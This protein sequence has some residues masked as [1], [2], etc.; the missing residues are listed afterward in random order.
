MDS[1]WSAGLSQISTEPSRRFDSFI[2]KNRFFLIS[3]IEIKIHIYTKSHQELDE[4]VTMN[5]YCLYLYHIRI[6]I[7]KKCNSRKKYC[8]QQT[9]WLENEKQR[10]S[11]LGRDQT[12]T[13][14]IQGETQSLY[15]PAFATLPLL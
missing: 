8:S 11:V 9:S 10:A 5:I 1:Q 15:S 7:E 2:T 12:V 13:K 14:R 3:I 6:K 4:T